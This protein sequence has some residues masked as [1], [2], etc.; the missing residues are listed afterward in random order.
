MKPESNFEM[1]QRMGAERWE[2]DYRASVDRNASTLMR[3]T[4]PAL[5]AELPHPRIPVSRDVQFVENDIEFGR[6]WT[7]EC[8]YKTPGPTFSHIVY[9]GTRQ[10]LPSERS[11]IYMTMLQT[12][13]KA[14]QQQVAD[15]LAVTLPIDNA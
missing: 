3:L 5:R 8:I 13:L 10:A 9:G 2:R 6:V 15:Y 4:D 12:A 1:I 14:V 7:V 11:R